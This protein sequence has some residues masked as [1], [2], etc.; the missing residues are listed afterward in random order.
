MT[1]AD[2]KITQ[3]QAYQ[4]AK[5]LSGKPTTD[6]FAIVDKTI[7]QLKQG[8]ILVETLFIS[9]DPYLRGAMRDFP[10]GSSIVSGNVAR[11]I[12]SESEKFA[13]G[14]IVHSY[15]PWARHNVLDVES[16]E[17]LGKLNIRAVDP[18]I[19]PVSTANG[20]LGM[21]GM[22]AYGGLVFVGKIKE[23]DNVFVSGAAGAV[24]SAV[25]QIA[26]ILGAKRVVGVVGSA[27]KA[28]YIK[29]LGFDDAIIYKENNDMKQM[30]AA[31]KQSMP[32]GIDVYFGMLHLCVCMCMYVWA[33]LY[34]YI[35]IYIPTLTLIR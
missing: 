20:I 14:T 1:D 25:G 11:V 5:P 16:P 21:P 22:T 33:C 23:G 8:E 18:A 35:Y 28:E 10:A 7:E 17:S 19:A 24:G 30:S 31:I 27:E 29:G 26:R 12:A 3:T 6:N 34:V 2:V 9:V 32:D 13:V 4:L 15:A